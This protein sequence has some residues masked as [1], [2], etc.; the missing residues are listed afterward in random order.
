MGIHRILHQI[1]EAAFA[2]YVTA[3]AQTLTVAHQSEVFEVTTTGASDT[4]TL[5]APTKPGTE[6]AVVLTVDA[7]DLTLT[8]TGGY[9]ADADTSITFADA[10]DYVKFASIQVGS[11]YYWRVVSQEG[12]NVAGETITVDTLT[13]TT[14]R[15]AVN[16]VA[17]AG[18]TIGQGGDL[19][20]GLNVVSAANNTTCVDLP[21]AVAGTVV[22]VTSQTAAK[23]LPVFP[24]VNT[25]IDNLSANAAKTIGA[26][27]AT[28]GAIFVADNATHWTTILGDTA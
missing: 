5:A 26:A 11:S 21:V 12:T 15:L 19:L 6:C 2:N 16:A 3:S 23:T 10:G 17:A 1:Y 20:A 28:T 24:A 8:V 4:L 9:N 7:G 14:L 18:S 27:T 13:A 22:V 25:A